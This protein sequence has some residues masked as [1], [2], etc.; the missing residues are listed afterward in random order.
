MR[1]T[2]SKSISLLIGLNL[3]V[4]RKLLYD[5]T[6]LATG[7]NR[8]KFEDEAELSVDTDDADEDKDAEAD[9][10]VSSET[11]LPPTFDED[12]LHLRGIRGVDDAQGVHLD[13]RRVSFPHS[14]VQFDRLSFVGLPVGDDDGY[15]PDS[16]PSADESLLRRLS[17]GG[18]GV[19]ALAHVRHL[20]DRLLDVL[21][22]RVANQVEL[23]MDVQAVEDQSDSGGVASHCGPVDQPGDKVLDDFKVLGADALRAVDDE[24]EL[25]RPLFALDAAS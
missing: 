23:Q 1:V 17:D 9:K 21:F 4:I 10:T 24:H 14:D 25:H 6:C 16:R 7:C 5:R 3:H 19:G 15:F 20:P 22:A 8:F 12:E 13:V 18:A 11:E 2:H